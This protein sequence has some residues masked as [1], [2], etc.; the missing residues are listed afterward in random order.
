L[1]QIAW[2]AFQSRRGAGDVD[3][4]WSGRLGC[5]VRRVVDPAELAMQHEFDSVASRVLHLAGQELALVDLLSAAGT[6]R[7]D[8]RWKVLERLEWCAHLGLIEVE[9]IPIPI[10]APVEIEP[11]AGKVDERESR[12]SSVLAELQQASLFERL[13]LQDARRKPSRSQLAEAFRAVSGRYHPDRYVGAPSAVRS[14]AERCFSLVNATADELKSPE[15][16]AEAWRQIETERSGGIYVDPRMHVTAQISFKKGEILFRNRRYGDA[17]PHFRASYAADPTS[18]EAAHLLFFCQY[19]IQEQTADEAIVALDALA[20]STRAGRVSVHLTVGRIWKL[21]GNPGR[22]SL[23]F[24]KAL[25][26]DPDCH[27]AKRELRLE[28]SRGAKD[29]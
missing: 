27:D 11:E 8:R 15:V 1:A 19:L 6:G 23:R 16:F 28:R 5:V 29:K 12:L 17:V 18:W 13:D 2:R 26:A 22:A 14:L 25:E 4:R 21:A 20:T 9:P 24:R 3:D 7:D 10:P